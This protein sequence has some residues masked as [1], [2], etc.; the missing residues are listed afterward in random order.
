MSIREKVIDLIRNKTTSL[1]TLPV[2]INN[3]I[4]MAKSD[5]TT[6][7]DLARFI[8]NDQA[9][10]ARVLKIANSPYYGVPKKI[11]SITR[12]IIVIGFKEIISVA[13]GSGVFK[14]LNPKQKD[15]LM[16][17]NELWKHS[18]GVGFAAKLLEQKSVIV[19]EEST[20]LM[21][22]LHDIGKILFL[23]YFPGDY[24]EVLVKQHND[25][26]SLHIVE[27][28]LLEIDH[29]EMAYLLMKQ[30][31]FPDNISIPIRYHHN[32][33]DC[34]FEYLNRAMTIHVGD[35]ICHNAEIGHST[36]LYTEKRD[37]V[38][39]TFG[40]SWKQVEE[41]TMTLR[42]ARPEVDDF[43]EALS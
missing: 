31:N 11:D 24:A 20:M 33:L 14:M 1:P 9:L 19:A 13:L 12:A 38:I 32:L 16:D 26:A 3:I 37:E 35:Y 8:S 29:S 36:N 25:R 17:M 4:V 43:L 41:L 40:L 42:D 21:G 7:N 39:S 23:I 27:K 22:L 2:I 34:P 30:W 15:T 6:A 28:E 10:S 18:I 5:N